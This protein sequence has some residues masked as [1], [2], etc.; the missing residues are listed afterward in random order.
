MP[1]SDDATALRQCIEQHPLEIDP[2]PLG[3]AAYATE[4]QW[5]TQR[6]RDAGD[7]LVAAGLIEPLTD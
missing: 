4:L 6:V 7:E 3:V 2:I 5:T 1:L